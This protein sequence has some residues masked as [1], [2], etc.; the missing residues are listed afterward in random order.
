VSCAAFADDLHRWLDGRPVH[1]RI[2]TVAERAI[3][4]VRRHRFVASLAA[5]ASIALLLGT[6]AALWQAREATRARDRAERINTFLQEMLGAADHSD[7]GRNAKLGDVL[8][9]AR[10]RAEFMLTDDPATLVA[11]E[12]TLAKAYDTIGDLDNALRS[13]NLGLEVAGRSALPSLTLDAEIA[14]S[15]V[16]INRGQFDD[17]GSLLKQARQRA[18]DG[19]TARQR[20]DSA[21]QFGFLETQRGN[22]AAAV[23]W[24]VTSLEELPPDLVEPRAAVMND[25]AVAED[26]AGDFAASLK[27][28]QP[29]IAL[30]RTAFPKGHPLLAQALGNLATALDDAGQHDA[31]SAIFDESLKMKIALM[32]E[33]HFSV[34]GTLSTMTWRSVQQK[35]VASALAYGARAWTSAQK[36]PPENPSADYA[37]ITYAQALMLAGRPREALPLV[38]EALR[39][40]RA[41]LPPDS[42]FVVNTES[43]LALAEAQAGD[44]ASGATLAQSAYARQLE[45]LGATHQLTVVAQERLREIDALKARAAAP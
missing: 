12:L 42:A 15:N 14:V 7:L 13:G 1:A 38:E 40:R 28:I 4:F 8:D 26:A 27:T 35:D 43:V 21:G 9:T 24:L 19:G 2:P 36:L 29:C 34:I 23:R 3:R 18:V 6:A 20:G 41:R 16:L 25:L 44:I 22:N 32:G 5:T 17:A 30:L 33:D 10:H 45:K 31:A 11:T 37:A 39:K